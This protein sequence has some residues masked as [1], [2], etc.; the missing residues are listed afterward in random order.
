MGLSIGLAMLAALA[1]ATSAVLQR[2]ANRDEP[3]RKSLSWRMIL[4]LFHRPV[5]LAGLAVVI[6]GFLLQAVALR[7]GRI[8]IVQPI[9]SLELPFVVVL[10]SIVFSGPPRP[11]EWLLASAMAGGL[12][13]LL[14]SL[15]PTPGKS[16]P[17]EPAQW[18]VGILINLTV[19]AFA[20]WRGR[21]NRYGRRA[22]YFGAAAG[23]SFGLT[24]A[25]MTSMNAA[26]ARAG[27]IGAVTTWET[28]LMVAAG[29]L[30]MF[31]LQ[32]ALQA[33][34]LVTA[35]PDRKSVV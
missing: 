14:A 13:L 16:A 29:L 17:V 1:N 10:S 24:A 34:R 23:M 18:A 21:A 31:L 5:W 35:Q 12:V 8:A 22:A 33:G 26:F 30:S 2:R 28:Y 4:D 19:V 9:L 27:L 6:T 32:N 11:T 3:D 15:A 7:G 20:I 25:L